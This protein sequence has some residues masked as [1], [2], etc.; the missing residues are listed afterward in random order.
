MMMRER[1]DSVPYRIVD[2]GGESSDGGEGWGGVG[3][4]IWLLL[5]WW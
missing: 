3:G 1:S 4:Q 2:E 5:W